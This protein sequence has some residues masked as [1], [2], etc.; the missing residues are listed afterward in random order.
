MTK[1]Y[2]HFIRIDVPKFTLSGYL[3]MIRR[4]DTRIIND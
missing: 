2:E 4:P 3:A 1:S